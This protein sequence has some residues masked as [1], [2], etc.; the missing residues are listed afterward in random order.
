MNCVLCRLYLSSAILYLLH[1][2]NSPCSKPC[3][4]RFSLAAVLLLHLPQ[5][6]PRRQSRSPLLLPL[7]LPLHRHDSNLPRHLF[8]PS[9]LSAISRGPRSEREARLL[10]RGECGL[11]MR[12]SR[13]L[14]SSREVEALLLSREVEILLSSEVELLLMCGSLPPGSSSR[15]F[16]LLSGL[17]RFLLRGS[18]SLF[19]LILRLTTA[20]LP[21]GGNSFVPVRACDISGRAVRTDHVRGRFVDVASLSSAFL[22]FW[23]I[24][25]SLAHG[26]SPW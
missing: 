15:L 16:L 9:F 24:L 2:L 26:N 11:R 21:V 13:F 10:W 20:P 25:T 22:V 18:S 12:R 7:A 5:R 4:L 23:S 19:L 6:L 1:L 8:S 14:L 17:S 3:Q